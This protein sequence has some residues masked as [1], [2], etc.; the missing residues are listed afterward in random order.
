MNINGFDNPLQEL[1][2]KRDAE[3][4][5]VH[6]KYAPLFHNLI[7]SMQ[8]KRT[9]FSREASYEGFPRLANY[10]AEDKGKV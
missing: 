7:A 3:V 2:A 5:A 9:H 10:E 8:K 6:N 4:Q 1:I